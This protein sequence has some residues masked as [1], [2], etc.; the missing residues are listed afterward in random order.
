VAP[1]GEALDVAL[2]IAADIASKS[3]AIVALGKRAF[4]QV[5]DLG[6]EAALEHLNGRLSINLL[7]EDAA[8]GIG[9][10]MGKRAP[11]WKDR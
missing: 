1:S 7:T 10:F 3:R 4:Y 2:T 5:A 8:E 11:L 6:Y 9:A